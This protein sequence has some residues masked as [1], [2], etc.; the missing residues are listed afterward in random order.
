[1][2][3]ILLTTEPKF[4][5]SYL[6][7]YYYGKPFSIIETYRTLS[8]LV[9]HNR[10]DFKQEMK[11]SEIFDEHKKL[12]SIV[13]Q[14]GLEDRDKWLERKYQDTEEITNNLS[15]VPNQSKP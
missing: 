4:N 3:F 2:F 5:E 15:P 14:R 9:E 11:K 1:M 10:F 8:S 6:E 7:S 12:L 13:K